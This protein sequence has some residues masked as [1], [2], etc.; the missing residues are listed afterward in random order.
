MVMVNIWFVVGWAIQLVEKAG[1]RKKASM[2][3]LRKEVERWEGIVENLERVQAEMEASVSTNFH[4]KRQRLIRARQRNLL[5][6]YWQLLLEEANSFI[7]F[8]S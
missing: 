6:S 3:K 7:S 1:E 5:N 8:T 2:H 4:R